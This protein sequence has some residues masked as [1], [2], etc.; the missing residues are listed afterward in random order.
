LGVNL[1][2]IRLGSLGLVLNDKTLRTL[3]EVP[4]TSR[5]I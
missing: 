5:Y 3:K 2:H 1:I 4:Y